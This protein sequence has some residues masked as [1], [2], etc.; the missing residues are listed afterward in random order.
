[1]HVRSFFKIRNFKKNH[2]ILEIHLLLLKKN[3]ENFKLVLLLN[4]WIKLGVKIISSTSKVK[5]YPHLQYGKIR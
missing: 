2:F 4:I 5:S 3:N 1:M